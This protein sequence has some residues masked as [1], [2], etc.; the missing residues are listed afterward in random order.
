MYGGRNLK[1]HSGEGGKEGERGGGEGGGEEGGLSFL[2]DG[3]N[4]WLYKL[5]PVNR[6]SMWFCSNCVDFSAN[7]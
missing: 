5:T 6:L 3:F 1:R 7:S 4:L 2:L